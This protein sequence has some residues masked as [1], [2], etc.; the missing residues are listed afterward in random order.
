MVSSTA[1]VKEAKM[2]HLLGRS[3]GT[4]LELVAIKASIQQAG[5]SA[6]SVE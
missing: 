1:S 2:D 3:K 5:T 4:H 6:L